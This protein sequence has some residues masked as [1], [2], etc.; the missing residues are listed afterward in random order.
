MHL[1]GI[2]KRKKERLWKK[3]LLASVLLEGLLTGSAS[4]RADQR[5][6]QLAGGVAGHNVKKADLGIVRDSRWQWWG[7][8]GYHFTVAGED[9][10]PYWDI[11]Q[12]VAA[13]IIRECSSDCYDAVVTRDSH[14][15]YGMVHGG[16]SS[17]DYSTLERVLG[18]DNR[19]QC[20][21]AVYSHQLSRERIR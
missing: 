6:V 13:A 17:E 3:A 20:D 1:S 5:S 4:A 11:R 16:D 9:H 14:R 15:C 2:R 10:V 8:G 19:V 12:K 21:A 7:I 18:I